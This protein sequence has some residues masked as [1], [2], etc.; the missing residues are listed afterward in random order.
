MIMKKIVVI[1]SLNMDMVLET[2]RMPKAGETIAGKSVMYA[3]GGKGAN[4]AYAVGKLGG[5]VSMIGAI[6]DD[7]FGAALKKNLEDVGVTTSGLEIIKGTPTGQAFITV[8]EHGE[9]SI[10]LISG[11][12]GLVTTKMIDD[13]RAEIEQSDIVV[14]QLEIPIEVVSYAKK[15]A[16]E[17]GKMIIIDPAPAVENLPD[18]FWDGIDYL[19]PNETELEILTGIHAESVEELKKGAKILQSKGVKNVI[20]TSGEKGCLLVSKDKEQVFLANK[21]PV[22]DTTAAGDS[23]TA[24]LALAL[25]QGKSCE[26]AIHFGQQVSAIVVSRK[27]AQ[28]SIP[29][30]EEVLGNTEN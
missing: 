3:P 4:Q 12:N 27:G 6:G 2:S 10:I 20:V 25:S 24:G 16:L 1:G 15:L 8:D 28:T 19:K 11:T 21:V 17:L 30:I 29:T 14:M 13:H 22:I 26:E 18:S 9:N 23:F 5:N 7:T